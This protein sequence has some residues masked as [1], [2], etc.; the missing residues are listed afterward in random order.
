MAQQVSHYDQIQQQIKKV[1]A[2]AF[3][4][5]NIKA[6]LQECTDGHW[7]SGFINVPLAHAI[8]SEL[9]YVLQP[10]GMARIYK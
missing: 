5:R 3:H 6:R 9:P 1:G 4:S 8:A 10:N 7:L 2:Q